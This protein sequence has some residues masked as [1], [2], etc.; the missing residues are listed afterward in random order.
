MFWLWHVWF[1]STSVLTQHKQHSVTHLRKVYQHNKNRILNELARF[2]NK[3]E[4]YR[5]N[6]YFIK[7]EM[8]KLLIQMGQKKSFIEEYFVNTIE[9]LEEEF[10]DKQEKISEK[11]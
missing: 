7:V 1:Q 8:Q 6:G 11:Y 9:R 3:I 4:T 10:K 2:D 5:K